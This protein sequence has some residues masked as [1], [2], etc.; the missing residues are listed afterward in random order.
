MI[1]SSTGKT[2]TS[3]GYRARDARYYLLPD[4]PGFSAGR[5]GEPLGRTDPTVIEAASAGL[6]AAAGPGL[7][8]RFVLEQNY[9]NPFNPSTRIEYTLPRAG[10]VSLGV[11]NLLG[12]RV[13][14]L[15]ENAPQAAGFHGFALNAPHWPSGVYFYR[16]RLDDGSGR[17]LQQTRKMVLVK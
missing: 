1:P 7:P 9:P 16:L 12:Q 17:A 10:R 3:P 4:S 8:C 13:A 11:Y 6:D 14:D 15:H 2:A 5:R